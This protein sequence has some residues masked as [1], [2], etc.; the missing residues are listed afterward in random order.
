MILFSILLKVIQAVQPHIV[1]VELCRARVGILQLDEEVMFRYAKDIDYSEFLYICIILQLLCWHIVLLF[2][3]FTETI[4]D[5]IK[6]EGLYDGL[7]HILLLRMAAYIAKQL[8]M[9]PGGEF[10]RA[11]EEVSIQY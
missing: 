10:R 6:K 1:V 4:M 9:P 2:N 7:I 5:I 11:F 8:G 3:L